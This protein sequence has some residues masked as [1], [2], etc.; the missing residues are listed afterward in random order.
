MYVQEAHG[1]LHVVNYHVYYAKPHKIH[2]IFM[3]V[4]N[5]AMCLLVIV[6]YICCSK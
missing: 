3:N 4:M 2:S 6:C 1:L 5:V